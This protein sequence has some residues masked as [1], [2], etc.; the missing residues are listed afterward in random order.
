MT[1]KRQGGFP[2]YAEGVRIPLPQPGINLFVKL[3]L[4]KTSLCFS[5]L[6]LA[7]ISFLY[8]YQSLLL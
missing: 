8:T 6:P 7:F 3:R 5:D 1:S 4:P 2:G